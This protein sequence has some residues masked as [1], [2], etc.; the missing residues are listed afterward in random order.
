MALRELGVRA[1]SVV[2]LDDIGR[3]LRPAKQMGM[4]TIKVTSASDA[5]AELDRVLATT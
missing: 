3:N 4:T 1:E 5:L 2:F